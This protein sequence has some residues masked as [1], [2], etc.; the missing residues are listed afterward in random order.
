MANSAGMTEHC[1]AACVLPG[2]TTSTLFLVV[3]VAFV[4]GGLTGFLLAAL[5]QMG[6]DSGERRP[7]LDGRGLHPLD[8]PTH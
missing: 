5:L 3:V 1:A 4:T 6:R 7:T 2:M 8:L